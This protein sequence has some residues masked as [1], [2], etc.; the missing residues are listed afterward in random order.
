MASLRELEREI[1]EIK[2]RNRKV[3]A[4]KAW[5]TSSARKLIISVFTYLAVAF[6]LQAINV[7]LP[8]LNAIVPTAAFLLSTLTLP[9]FKGL[10]L[11]RH[12]H[13]RTQE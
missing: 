8:W 3:E 7:P 13:V 2:E 12:R 9:F 6:Y 5:E 11:K 4:D 1:R 10:W